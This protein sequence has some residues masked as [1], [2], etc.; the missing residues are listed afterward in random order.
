MF[1]TLNDNMI[2]KRINEMIIERKD[3]CTTIFNEKCHPFLRTK[4][5]SQGQFLDS[6]KVMM[7]H[8]TINNVHVGRS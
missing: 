5:F 3:Y 1:G 7:N 4:L 8:H 6:N 2:K